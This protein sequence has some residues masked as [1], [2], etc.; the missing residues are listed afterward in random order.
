MDELVIIELIFYFLFLHLAFSL[1]FEK[2]QYL[3]ALVQYIRRCFK[4]I[5]VPDGL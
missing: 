1:T 2:Y 3:V 5:K 4:V